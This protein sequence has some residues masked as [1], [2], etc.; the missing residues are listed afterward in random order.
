M[1]EISLIKG[2]EIPRGQIKD[3]ENVLLFLQDERY[4]I[5]VVNAHETE[6]DKQVIKIL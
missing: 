4:L 2:L 6:A 3:G 5:C 1:K